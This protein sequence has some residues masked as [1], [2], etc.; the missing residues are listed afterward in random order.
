MTIP[1]LFAVNDARNS[2][3][4]SRMQHLELVAKA[5]SDARE[6]RRM[7][8]G[9]KLWGLPS[10]YDGPSEYFAKYD[11]LLL[12]V[13]LYERYIL[14]LNVPF[15]RGTTTPE[16]AT[17][18]LLEVTRVN[19]GTEYGYQTSVPAEKHVWDCIRWSGDLR[20][21]GVETLTNSPVDGF[22]RFWK[23]K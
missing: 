4:W 21:F 12:S 14:T 19:G 10:T 15:E 7:Y 5:S 2:E 16:K 13:G 18:R 9:T 1:F 3:L 22:E 6:F 11:Q 20:A 23:P 17:F 8:P